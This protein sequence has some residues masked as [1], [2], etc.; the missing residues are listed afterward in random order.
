MPWLIPLLPD[1]LSTLREI[2][3]R[4]DGLFL[5]GGVDVDPSQYGETKQPYCGR[6][7]LPRDHTESQLIRWALADHRPILAVC[8]GIQVVNVAMGG[9]LFQD[10]SAEF[11]HAIK[12]DYFPTEDHSA[13][14]F[15]AHS[16]DVSPQSRLR[17]LLGSTSV[18]V[19][20]MHHQA[21]KN[22]APGLKTTATA[23][24]G[25]IEGVEGTNGQ[26]L[27]AVQWHPEEL[28]DRD[29]GMRRLFES[30]IEAA[31]HS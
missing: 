15:L 7:D 17:Q 3:D 23:P 21:I 22:L 27:L 5:T 26:Y 31:G 10:L 16:I 13:R 28:Y 8:R 1:D 4:L 30:F 25:V 14:D 18:K 20:S 12:H 11:T 24:D 9:S 29:E 2:H 19:N 6:T